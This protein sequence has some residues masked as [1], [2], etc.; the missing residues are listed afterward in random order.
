MIWM[1]ILIHHRRSEGRNQK[2]R[3]ERDSLIKERDELAGE[4]QQETLSNDEIQAALNY[5]ENV[6]AGMQNPTFEDKRRH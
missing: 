2:P 5:R 1:I 4:L 6:M 3:Q